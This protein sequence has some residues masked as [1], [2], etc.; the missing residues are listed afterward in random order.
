MID[1]AD[2]RGRTIVIAAVVTV[3]LIGVVILA[4]GDSWRGALIAWILR[5]PAK[6]RSRVVF[7]SIALAAAVILPVV[8]A[9]AYLWRFGIRVVRDRRFPPLGSWLIVDTVIL[10]GVEAHQY[11][12]LLQALAIG[13]GA[14]GVVLAIMFWRLMVLTTPAV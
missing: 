10:E 12:R 5:D 4:L 13:L 9:A 6:S 7:V 8:G 3:V 2:A 1:K 14:S 11:G